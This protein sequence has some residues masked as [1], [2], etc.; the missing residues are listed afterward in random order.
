MVLRVS[1]WYGVPMKNSEPAPETQRQLTQARALW[2]G[3]ADD[4]RT[5]ANYLYN[6][7]QAGVTLREIA[8]TLECS[9]MTAQRFVKAG[10]ALACERENFSG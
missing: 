4:R 6:V 3:L 9:V 1:A 2:A 5:I 10:E 7:N 8:A